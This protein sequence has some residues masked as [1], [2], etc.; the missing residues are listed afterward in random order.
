MTSRLITTSYGR[1]ALDALRAV[2]A[3][4]KRDDPM[5]PVT[6]LLPNN[7]AGI[8][9]RRHLAHGIRDGR[10]GIAGIYL[11]TLPRL[12]ERLASPRLTAAGR[13]PAT[14]PITAAAWRAVLNEDPGLFEQVA[15]HP[16]T[17]RALTNAHR[18][19]RDLTAEAQHAVANA[20]PLGHDLV[21]LHCEVSDRLSERWYDPTDLL[22]TAADIVNEHPELVAEMAAII[23]H[24]P[25]GLT[26][27]EST[28]A[29]ALADRA[30]LTVIAGLTSHPRADEATRRT[31]QR[32]GLEPTE[33]QPPSPTASEVF[34]ASDA[35]DEVRC[36]VRKVAEMLTVVP[37]HRVAILYGTSTPYARLLHEHLGAAGISFNG[38]GVRAVHERATARC[39]L[40]VL[41]LAEPDLPR[42]DLFRA[43]AEAPTR[44]FDGSLVPVS[45]WER[46][47]RS[48]GVVSGDDWSQ[49]L[50]IY[51]DHE[52]QTIDTE[53]KRE[54]SY[55]SRIE[56]A[57]RN[58]A[59]ASEL[60][61]FATTLRTRLQLGQTLT[62]WTDLSEWTSQ[63]FHDLVGDADS[64]TRL[65][66]EEQYAA[67]AVERV[68]RALPS[69]DGMGATAS[70]RALRDVL[71]L[72]LE[73]ALPRVG[74]FGDGVLVAPISTSIGLEG[75]VIY[76]LGL[77]EDVYPGRLHEDALLPERIRDATHGELPS[78]RERVDSKHRHLLAAFSSGTRVVASYPR[79]DLRR[80]SQRIPSRW[81]LP[82]LRALSGDE[83]L[84]AT[85][86]G[87][88]GD[89]W[90]AQSP[91]Y[92]SSLTADPPATEQ[93]W[94]V[95]AA[96]ARQDLR[97]PV[98]DSGVTLVRARASDPLTRFDGNLV[99]AEGLPDYTNGELT[100]SP[101]GLETYADCPHQ[102]FVKR[103][104][105]VE[106]IEQPEE[107]VTISPLDIGTMMHET[108]EEL[109]KEHRDDLP[110]YGEPWTPQHKQR[111][112][113]IADAKAREFEAEGLTGHP[114]LWQRERIRI[115]ADLAWMLDD[116]SAWR[117][118]RAAQV[119]ASELSFGMN[120]A[121]AVEVPVPGGRVRLRGSADKIDQGKDGTLY[122]TDIKT[123]SMRG[124]K[125][126]GEAD[127]VLGGAKLQL[128]VYAY[129]A[130]QQLG[131]P[132]TSVEASYW[133]VRKDRGKRIPVPLTPI[134]EQTYAHAL[135]VIVSSIAAG[136][137]PPRP[138]D[139]PDYGYVSCAY[140][141]PDG[142]GYGEARTRW[143]RKRLA[144]ALATYVGL[145]EPEALEAGDKS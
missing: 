55:P 68:L 81:L 5:A 144:P 114:R 89:G 63:L 135:G 43:L 125:G 83:T 84:A 45:R 115:L 102:F 28:L 31:L 138:P 13:R 32:L 95:R 56:R 86:V 78:Y 44:T 92:A 51:I 97:D 18:E 62:T 19:L 129:A 99:G 106:P 30:D 139:K 109:I 103:L 14:R 105:K 42:A 112:A 70:Y 117:E 24:L 126:L 22:R 26:Q 75:D 47:S 142:V 6:L 25:Q 74:R 41:S 131:N 71:E 17:I 98:V 27:A 65:P 134:V 107:L 58:I 60:Q 91:S 23:L 85:D 120:G 12:A 15:E 72:E 39:L 137:F 145:V 48:A 7:I 111:L 2:V 100:I 76:V 130:R 119:V 69:L 96:S 123:G 124:F 128:P 9:A 93:E 29:S 104:L 53:R 73:T 59:A 90:L 61:D 57:E 46:I 49:R 110:S 121:P 77:A 79:G 38:Q 11:A 118:Q 54:D 87:I 37:A 36:L 66:P 50:T 101:T 10:P 80:H 122:V 116:D 16:A 8:V 140:C 20:S 64:L 127:P 1:A 143:E 108:F 34:N 132:A 94:R 21:R 88:S 35:D 82:T 133:F 40:E 141:N 3:E 67:A 136:M 33:P 4:V 113:E 52:Q